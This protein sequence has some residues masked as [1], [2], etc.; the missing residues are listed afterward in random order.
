VTLL[1]LWITDAENDGVGLAV[2]TKTELAI[3]CSHNLTKV[4][5]LDD[6]N[7][8]PVFFISDMHISPCGRILV[9]S[10]NHEITVCDV[11]ANSIAFQHKGTDLRTLMLSSNLMFF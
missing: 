6:L 10:G 8:S 3:Y 5:V 1:P 4:K 2:V 11:E 7:K 9:S